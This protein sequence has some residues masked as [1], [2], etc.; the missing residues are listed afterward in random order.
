[1][2]L[3]QQTMENAACVMLTLRELWY[4]YVSAS[5]NEHG[6]TFTHWTITLSAATIHPIYL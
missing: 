2:L 3:S 5:D 4:R 1:V 6:G